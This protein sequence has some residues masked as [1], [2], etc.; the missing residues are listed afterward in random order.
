MAIASPSINPV[1]SEFSVAHEAAPPSPTSS[2][3]GQVRTGQAA[4]ADKRS[5]PQKAM[6][7]LGL[8]RDID[9]ALHLPLRYEDETRLTLLREARDGETVQVEGVV[10]DNRI[11]SR[12]RRQLI[13]R[14]HDGSG[15][16][17]LRFL[18]FYGSQQKSWGAGVRLRARGAFLPASKH[19]FCALKR[20]GRQAMDVAGEKSGIADILKAKQLRR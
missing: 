20:S 2:A 19:P 15:E 1:L 17:L 5:P 16:V 12:G 4:G 18:N 7:R 8:T 10:R 9:L 3:R 11:E 14:L 13:V 6:E